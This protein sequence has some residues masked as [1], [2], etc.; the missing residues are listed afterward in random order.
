MMITKLLNVGAFKISIEYLHS[1]LLTLDGRVYL[2]GRNCNNQ[3]TIDNNIDQSSPKLFVPNNV[4]DVRLLDVACTRHNTALLTTDFKFNYI[5][6]NCDGML[7]LL[8]EGNSIRDESKLEHSSNNHNNNS[9]NHKKIFL[10]KTGNFVLYNKNFLNV[11]IMEYLVDE[12]KYLEEMLLMHSSVLKQLQRVNHD[13]T[14]FEILCRNYSELIYFNAA[15]VDTLHSYF[16]NRL[17]SYCDII[18][19]KQIDEFIYFYK[20]YLNTLY[21]FNSIGGSMSLNQLIDVPPIIYKHLN[22]QRDKVNEEIINDILMKPFHK[23]KH[24]NNMILK[25]LDGDKLLN[26][27]RSKWTYF[28]EDVEQKEIA[29][30]RTN[31]FWANS[32]KVIKQLKM[33]KRRLIRDSHKNPIYLLNA[34]RFSSHWFVLFND[35]FVH[36]SGSTVT[37]HDLRTV[38]VEPQQEEEDVTNN[39]YQLLLKMPEDNYILYTQTPDEKMEWLH[40]FQV[41]INFILGKQINQQIPIIRSSSYTFK[42][43]SGTLKDAKYSGRWSRAKMYGSGQMEWSD[44][45]IYTGQFT[46]N[47]FHG[48]G[49]MKMPGRGKKIYTLR[50]GTLNV[51]FLILGTYEGQWMENL[52]NGFGIM[53]YDNGDIYKG[54]FKD[55]LPHGHG[56]LKQGKFMSSAAFIYIGDFVNGN[57]NG[58]GVM[59]DIAAGEKYLGNWV[60]N[61]KQGNGIL[62]TTD[63]IYYEGTFNQDTLTVNNLY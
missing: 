20:N 59:D 43:R 54:F 18:M 26:E 30:K 25:L 23:I 63:G 19:F 1:A 42:T 46:N 9:N 61:R 5:G 47:Q 4:D 7:E 15:N 13:T 3:V 37:T 39:Q 35:I 14:L 62:V 22:V 58:Y 53:K 41:T 29:A 49:R 38:W 17:S 27:I 34:S 60:D 8:Y 2:W 11:S 36:V 32:G 33:P 10:L 44:G 57:K 56:S 40:D 52:Q 51:T 31:L 48:F 45:K 12:Q 50:G 24:Y 21:D 6:K 28:T 16:V 55:G